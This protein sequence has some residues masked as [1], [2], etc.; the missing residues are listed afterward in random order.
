M[1]LS[2]SVNNISSN[3]SI[4]ATTMVEKITTLTEA[5]AS[6][7]D[8]HTTFASSPMHSLQNWTNFFINKPLEYRPGR[9][10][11]RDNRFWRPGLYQLSY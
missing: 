10:R 1:S 5:T 9:T 4:K 6:L 3:P 7:L 8:G 2:P 11:T